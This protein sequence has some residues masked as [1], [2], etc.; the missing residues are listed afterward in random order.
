[1][2][3]N[4]VRI[5]ILAIG[6]SMPFASA[7]P[8]RRPP[9]NR[10]STYEYTL[11][12][13]QSR[14]KESYLTH[15]EV[16]AIFTLM[17]TR[18]TDGQRITLVLMRPETTVMRR[19]LWEYLGLTPS[20]YRESIDSKSADSTQIVIIVG[21]ES[22]MISRVGTTPGAIGFISYDTHVDEY[23]RVKIMNTR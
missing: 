13:T 16:R 11:L 22:E 10:N 6:M 7:H 20:S 5:A 17:Q 3:L 21:S 23:R 1:M 14:V 12:I 18:W 19:F 15:G 9:I 2:L 4:V 8:P